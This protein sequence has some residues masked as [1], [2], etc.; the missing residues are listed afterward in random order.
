MNE[1]TTLITAVAAAIPVIATTILTL[2]DQQRKK[3][4][5]ERAKLNKQSAETVQVL[6]DD[7]DKLRKRVAELEDEIH[8]TEKYTRRILNVLARKGILDEVLQEVK[9]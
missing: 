4:E 2:R 5:E 1:Y 6:I 3:I 8:K 9:E 7:V